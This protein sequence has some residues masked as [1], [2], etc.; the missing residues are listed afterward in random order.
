MTKT[1]IV[2]GATGYGA[3]PANSLEGA[4]RC[5]AAPVNGIEIDVQMTSDGHR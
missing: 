1:L 4:E 3:W 5:I 2:A